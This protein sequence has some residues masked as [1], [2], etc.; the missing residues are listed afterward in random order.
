MWF[1]SQ[2][3]GQ[4]RHNDEH[5]AY[6]F[7]GSRAGKNDPNYEKFLFGP[8]PVGRYK[9]DVPDPAGVMKLDPDP[10]NEMFGRSDFIIIPSLNKSVKHPGYIVLAEWAKK[11]MNDSLDRDL[12]VTHE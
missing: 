8:I 2:T 7:S 3:T 4:L 1:Y 6:G 11:R 5:V 9:I 12:L 10:A